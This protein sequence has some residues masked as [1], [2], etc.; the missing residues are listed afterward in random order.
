M[1]DRMI[2]D[3]QLLSE[4]DQKTI[5]DCKKSLGLP[6]DSHLLVFFARE[7]VFSQEISK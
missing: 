5:D 7:A 2:L 1:D 3:G 4:K 6:M